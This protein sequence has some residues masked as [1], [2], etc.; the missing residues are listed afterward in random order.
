M[1]V[2]ILWGKGTTQYPPRVREIQAVA[3]AVRKRATSAYAWSNHHILLGDFNIFQTDNETYHALVNRGFRIP[4]KLQGL[5]SNI[6]R[7]RHYDQIAFMTESIGKLISVDDLECGLFDA[8]SVVYRERDAETY[9]SR[10]TDYLDEDDDLLQ[11]YR[12]WRT[13]QLSDHFPMWV[14]LRTDHAEEY[15]RDHRPT[16]RQSSVVDAEPGADDP[17]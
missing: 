4:R 13:H 15:L 5:P 3:K 10:F 17:D 12:Q 7:T 1:T 16:L 11:V 6:A 14:R 8:F 2:H 9:R